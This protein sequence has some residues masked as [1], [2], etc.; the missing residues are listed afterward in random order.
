MFDIVFQVH[1]VSTYLHE[2]GI[3]NTT[4]ILGIGYD[5][6]TTTWESGLKLTL[7]DVA[8]PSSPKIAAF[9]LDLGSSTDAQYDFQ[10]V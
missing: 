4:F 7:F 8:N 10:A 6:N 3:D 9:Y 2:I 1:G 5:W